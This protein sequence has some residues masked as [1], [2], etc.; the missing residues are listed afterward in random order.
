MRA[1]LLISCSRKNIYHERREADLTCLSTA[2]SPSRC[3]AG[4]SIYDHDVDSGVDNLAPNLRREG[5][6]AGSGAGTGG[7]STTFGR[8]FAGGSTLTAHIVVLKRLLFSS[9]PLFSRFE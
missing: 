9:S 2:T 7:G 1:R 4:H 3:G 6:G 5:A 8:S